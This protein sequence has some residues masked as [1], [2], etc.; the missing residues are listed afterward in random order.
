MIP[1]PAQGPPN[2]RF[3]IIG[4][5]PDVFYGWWWCFGRVPP[6]SGSMMIIAMSFDAAYRL[7][8]N[9]WNYKPGSG[10]WK[11]KQ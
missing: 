3:L 9:P 2:R 7:Y 11:H 6:R 8:E 4:F 1:D 5:C 10:L